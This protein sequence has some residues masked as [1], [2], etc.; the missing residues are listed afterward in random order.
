[1][2][3]VERLLKDATFT[4]VHQYLS[5]ADYK[6][7][8]QTVRK[9]IRDE[10]NG[11]IDSWP[12]RVAHDY[13]SDARRHILRAINETWDWLFAAPLD[14]DECILSELVFPAFYNEP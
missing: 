7:F 10:H 1:M 14:H 4:K 3:A 11:N 6:L 13:E 9:A 8:T 5:D 2:K 12:R